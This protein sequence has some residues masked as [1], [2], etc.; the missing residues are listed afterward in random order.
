MSFPSTIDVAPFGTLQD[1]GCLYELYAMIE[2]RSSST[3]AVVGHYIAKVKGDD[4]WYLMDDDADPVPISGDELT[5]T[6]TYV[7]FYRRSLG[8]IT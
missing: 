2:H 7:L 5:S 8:I 3:E 1:H 6:G 4:S